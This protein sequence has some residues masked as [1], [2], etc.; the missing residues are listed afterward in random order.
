M[1]KGKI[2]Y[3]C[4]LLSYK[5]TKPLVMR[6]LFCFLMCS[7][8]CFGQKIENYTK[9]TAYRLIEEDSDGP[10]SVL[11][12]F[13]EDGLGW[14]I[15]AIKSTDFNFASK[16]LQLHKEARKTWPNSER[17]CKRGWIGMRTIPNMFIIEINA[18]RDTIFTTENNA[19]FYSFT[20]QKE[21]F[22]RERKLNTI[23]P[24][25]MK[26][27][28]AFNFKRPYEISEELD[29]IDINT[30]LYGNKLI[31]GLN[32]R[33]FETTFGSFQSIT[34]TIDSLPNISVSVSYSIN[35]GN[36][37]FNYNY[38]KLEKIIFYY[39]NNQGE[40]NPDEIPLL[41]DGITI[42][43]DEKKLRKKFPGSS[44]YKSYRDRRFK[45]EDLEDDYNYEIRLRDNK[46]YVIFNIKKG[47]ISEVEI[48][49]RYPD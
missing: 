9:V 40:R 26:E 49:F 42:P 18:Y 23:L 29:S 11:T 22:D 15:K 8:F 24:K 21:Y 48:E 28:F 31:Y 27:F 35:D 36:L 7:L 44:N 6:F 25:E 46:G 3:I 38:G 20:D 1:H 39:P 13:K 12:Y 19:A 17:S 43:I 4:L 33:E 2:Y 45:V 34:T 41:I 37:Y 14:Y 32:R 47:M 5:V 30:I 16:L 10:C